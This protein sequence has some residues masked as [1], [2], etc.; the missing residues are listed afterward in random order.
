MIN[1]Q[2]WSGQITA[3]DGWHSS[4]N[5]EDIIRY[6]VIITYKY[7]VFGIEAARLPPSIE[8][9]PVT[10]ITQKGM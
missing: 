7:K 1:E 10:M 4:N 5:D 2:Q 6:D 8:N 3:S 9:T